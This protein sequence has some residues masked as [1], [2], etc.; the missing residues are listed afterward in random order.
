MD[1]KILCALNQLSNHE[2][3]ERVKTL[4]ERERE[5]TAS[6][7]AHLA[8]LD[9][10]QLYL[11]E[12]YSSLFAYCT[13]ELSLSESAA[14]RRIVAARTIRRF[15][16]ILEML[17]QG[18][19]NL[20]TVRLLADHLTE[21]NHQE[22]L[23]AARLKSKRQVEELIARLHPLPPVPS[24]IRKLPTPDRISS[25]RPAENNEQSHLQ[26]TGNG[27]ENA[28]QDMSSLASA[29]SRDRPATIIPL[30]PERYKVQFTASAE[31]HKKLRIAQDLLRHQ[32]PNGD[33]AEIFDLA[34]TALLESIAKKKL[35]ATDRPRES[36]DRVSNSRHI[37]AEVKRA[38]W[39]RDNGRCTFM[40]QN[41][42]GCT[43]QGFLE[44]HHVTPYASGGAPTLDN[45]QLR[46][47]AHNGYEAEVHFRPRNSSAVREERAS[48]LNDATTAAHENGLSRQPSG[49][50]RSHKDDHVSDIVWLSE[51]SERDTRSDL[52]FLLFGNPTRLYIDGT[53]SIFR[54]VEEARDHCRI[55]E[56]GF[57]SLDPSADSFDGLHGI[58]RR[59]LAEIGDK[60]TR[61]L[62][63]KGL[64][65][66]GADAMI[67]TS[68]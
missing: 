21:E 53:E 18:W 23:D 19:V 45:I 52:R 56:V 11:A 20:T 47:R 10:R 2:L 61:A 31:T 15:P 67:G 34:L 6:V 50:L 30:A 43:E 13:Q 36:R 7:I 33:P 65:R 8:E 3:L 17:E 12:G 41:G 22:V 14:F 4:A 37:P 60:D 48:Y 62:C 49:L 1:P 38:V 54:P 44:Y 9:A 28:A 25:M 64:C 68:D 51:A 35:A 57:P 32:I 59:R 58:C 55:S 42:R 63:C 26:P 66:R 40:G 27:Q 29:P 16:G 39:L 24:I 5:A 46:C